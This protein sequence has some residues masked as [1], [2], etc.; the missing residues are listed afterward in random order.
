MNTELSAPRAVPPGTYGAATAAINQILDLGH[1]L[2]FFP[3]VIAVGPEALELVRRHQQLYA[4]ALG[5]GAPWHPTIVL[6]DAAVLRNCRRRV[7]ALGWDHPVDA[8][9][10]NLARHVHRLVEA[11][12]D[13]STVFTP[14]LWKF[15]GLFNVVLQLSIAPPKNVLQRVATEDRDLFWELACEIENKFWGA[16]DWEILHQDALRTNPYY[17]VLQLVSR[18]LYPLGVESDLFIVFGRAAGS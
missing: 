2:E 10:A 7:N 5:E 17:P 9:T 1:A 18:G 4:Q 3:E 16:I 14:P 8:W 12:P 6:G 15:P 13:R 11:L